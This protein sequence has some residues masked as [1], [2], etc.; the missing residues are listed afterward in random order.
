MSRQGFWFGALVVGLSL[1]FHGPAWAEEEGGK[2]MGR[3]LSEMKL[4]VFP[5]LPTCATGAVQSGDPTKGPAIILAKGGKGCT[6]PWH[7]H[8]AAERLM[9]VAGTAVVDMKDGRPFTLKPG[10]FLALPGRHVHHFRCTSG[11]C[12]F[13]VDTDGAFDIHYVDAQGKE[14]P[15]EQALKAVKE[16]VAK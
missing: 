16:S 10:G 9:M 6:V 7:W 12:T 1:P 8:T 5:G 15:P 3:N 13:Y 4:G 11:P 14:I 2:P